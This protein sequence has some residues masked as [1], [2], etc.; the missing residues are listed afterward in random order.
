MRSESLEKLFHIPLPKVSSG[1]KK[2]D[3]DAYKGAALGTGA[4]AAGVG[5]GT[6]GYKKDNTI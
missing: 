2:M 6:L 5:A 1:A 4:V 3:A